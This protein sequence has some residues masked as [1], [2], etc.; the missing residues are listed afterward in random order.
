M[1][2]QTAFINQFSTK[3]DIEGLT[4]ID[5]EYDY[6]TQQWVGN[7]T[8][9]KSYEKSVKYGKIVDEKTDI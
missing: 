8:A 5:G 4:E 2:I 9:H 1:K 6:N 7:N 3:V